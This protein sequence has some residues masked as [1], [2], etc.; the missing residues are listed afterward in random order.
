MAYF[1][2]FFV[3]VRVVRVAQLGWDQGVGAK[4]WWLVP[5]WIRSVGG[6]SVLLFEK[7]LMMMVVMIV[8]VV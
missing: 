7:L 4:G 8:P 6:V 5:L 3:V 1:R 2:Y